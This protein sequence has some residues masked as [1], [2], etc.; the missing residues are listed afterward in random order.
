MIKYLILILVIVLSFG[1]VGYSLIYTPPVEHIPLNGIPDRE[2]VVDKK[3][4]DEVN[5]WRIE[6]NLPYLSSDTVVCQI[7]QKRL[8]ETEKQWNHNGFYKYADTD[9]PSKC[10]LG[11]NLAKDFSSEDSVLESWINSD[12]H[13]KNLEGDYKHACVATDGNHV[14]MI[15]GDY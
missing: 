2:S 13:R 14:V 11:E 7:A 9:C 15:F 12:S 4:F 6:N 5:R 10:I 1:F 3:I 8:S